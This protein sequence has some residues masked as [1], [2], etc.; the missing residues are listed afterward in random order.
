MSAITG[1]YQFNNTAIKYEHARVIMDEFIHFPSDEIKIWINKH[2]FFGC[3][4]QWI[5]PESISEILP[6]YDSIRKL[7]I[8]ADA[9]ID[10]REELFD[11]LG[12]NQGLRKTMT[13]SEL[14]LLTYEK[15]K[16]DSPKYLVGDFAYVIWDEKQEMIFGARDFSGSRTLYYAYSNNEFCF[17][18]TIK[19]LVKISKS[20]KKLNEQWIAEFLAISGM[21]DTVDTS[22]T[23]Y[24]NINQ[25]QPSHSFILKHGKVYIQQYCTLSNFKTIRYKNDNDYIESF[26]EV[27][28]EAVSSRLRS[29]KEIGAQLSGGLDSGAIAGFA[30]R[31]L[32]KTGKKL[33]TYS[34]IPPD[35]F[36]D[37]TPRHLL[38]DETPLIKS[39]VNFVGNIQDNY[40]S[41]EGRDPYSEIDPFL[42]VMEM[43]YKFFENSFWLKGMFEE[44]ARDNVGILLNGGRGNLSISWG[45]AIEYYSILLKKLKWIK[46]M[47][48]LHLYSLNVGGSRYKRIPSIAQTAFPALNK[49]LPSSSPYEIP[50]PLNED[51]AIKTRVYE[52]LKDYGIGDNG[53]FLDDNI[54]NQR[55]SHFKEVFHWNASNTLASKLSMQYSLWKRDPSNDLRVIRYCLSLPEEQYVQNGLDRALIRNATKNYLPND[56]RLNQKVRGVQGAD[57]VHR[58]NMNS[59]WKKLR[60]EIDEMVNDHST[61]HIFNVPVI[62]EAVENLNFGP[63]P[64][65]AI[66][67]NYKS[68]MR[69]L[70]VYRFIKNFI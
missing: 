1:I 44:A 49:I 21:V 13:D 16:E 50:N 19:P 69:C 35:D 30:S 60:I 52:K 40:L 38:T 2:L 11:R 36:V 10:N 4:A 66:D 18:S 39:T 5:T 48:E 26:Q 20:K 3:H 27:F 47:R 46:L 17:S 22:I 29:Y 70:V 57:W 65:K 24:Q 45:S 59:Q 42:D 15:W 34:Y 54:Y 12:V 43:P 62:K 55:K 33:H 6:Y 37:F 9:I 56:I 51:L 7:A 14:I 28:H 67:P 68:L 58:M 64:E 32:K 23:P 8:T 63:I 41:F 61:Q 31:K 53:W 25:L